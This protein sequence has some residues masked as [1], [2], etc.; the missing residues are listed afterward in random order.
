MICE[1]ES[2]NKPSCSAACLHIA[3]VSSLV[4]CLGSPAL[5]TK[6]TLKHFPKTGCS[7]YS[8]CC[9]SLTAGMK[10]KTSLASFP[11]TRPRIKAMMLEMITWKLSAGASLEPQ[12]QLLYL[13]I[14]ELKEDLN[15]SENFLWAFAKKIK[16]SLLCEGENK[17]WFVFI[18]I[19]SNIIWFI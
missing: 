11:Q 9:S 1:T 2:R 6:G 3:A 4:V 10:R 16:W 14:H 18:I 12:E 13:C 7:V 15:K 8:W 19:L 17:G 5:Q